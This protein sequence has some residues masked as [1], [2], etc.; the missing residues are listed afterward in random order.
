M[1]QSKQ[2]KKLVDDGRSVGEVVAVDR[3]LVTLRGLDNAPLGS[4]IVFNDGNIGLIKEAREDSILALSVTTEN[5]LLGQLAVIK[6]NSFKIGVG[7]ELLGKIVDPLG[8]SLDDNELINTPT[9][10]EVFAEAPS[11]MERSSLDEQLPSGIA[12]IDTLFS[13]IQGQRIAVMGDR[14][15]GKT[16][17]L[18]RLSINQKPTD[19]VIIYALIGK[20]KSEL[21]LLLQLF[22]KHGILDQMVVVSSNIMDPLPAQYLTPYSACAIAEHFWNE[23]RDCVIVYDDLS[24]HAK[25]Y[26]EMSLLLRMNPGRDSYSSDIFYLHSSLLERAGKLKSNK[27]SLT[28]V[29]VVVTPNNDITGYIPTNI[30]SI[31]DGQI[32]LDT[33]VFQEGMRPAVN[34]GLSVSRIAERAW[35]N[36]QKNIIDEVSERLVAYREAKQFARFGARFS[37]KIEEDLIIG[38]QI[39]EFFQQSPEELIGLVEQQVIL[40]AILMNK[41]KKKLDISKMKER[42]NN[43]LSDIEATKDFSKYAEELINLG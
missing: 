17:I 30:I 36:T 5:I 37:D 25:A 34:V 41:G 32:F 42:A 24:N 6:D 23:G 4:V 28:A 7:D 15:A 40:Q 20:Q 14:K 22:K 18:T 29:P 3:F 31:T 39:Y 2:F 12:V 43:M 9:Q 8:H 16:S 13:I 21:E 38:E 35:T 1:L 33:D 10:R 26:R 19:R 27:K 11:I